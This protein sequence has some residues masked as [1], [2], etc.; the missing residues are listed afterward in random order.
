MAR[1]EPLDPVAVVLA[2]GDPFPSLSRGCLPS[3]DIVIAAD[4]GL[5]QAPHLGLEVDLVVG[6]LDS[7]DPVA[8]ERATARGA[9]IERHPRD[10]DATDLELALDAA[11]ARGAARVIVIGGTGGRLDH[12]LGNVA[13]LGADKYAPMRVELRS[14]EGTVTVVR[15]GD[16]PLVIDAIEGDTITLLPAGGGALAITTHGLEYPLRAEDLP[17]GT[18]RGVSNVVAARPATVALARGTLLVVVPSGGAR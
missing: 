12:F 16:P 2:G 18:T 11:R 7:A 13:L 9:R 10:K 4:S 5:H 17:T 6:D 15:G 14:A 1:T 3:A 8:V